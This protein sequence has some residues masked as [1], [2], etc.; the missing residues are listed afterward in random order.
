MAAPIDISVVVPFYNEQQVAREFHRRLSAVME[1]LDGAITWEAVY[2]DDGS[3][4]GTLEVLKE[5]QRTDDRV[6]VVELS[7][8]WGHQPAVMA[9]LCTSR[10]RA[11]VLMDGDL[12][13]PPEVIPDLLAAWREGG[14]VI[15][16]RRRSRAERGVRRW[17]FGAFYAVLGFLTDYPI[18][19]N[20]GI[21]GLLD[22]RV[23]DAIARMTET[24]RYLPGLRSYA[25]FAQRVVSYDRAERAGGEPK[26]TFGRLLKYGLDAIF[27]FSY[28]PLRLATLLGVLVAALAVVYGVALVVFRLLDTGMFGIPVVDGYTSTIVSVLILGALQ[29]ITIGILGEYLGRVYDEVKRRPLFLIS[30]I[31]ASDPTLRDAVMARAQA[32]TRGASQGS[33]S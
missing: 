16:G 25:G 17:M 18:P 4:D 14:Q 29:L 20:A 7:R 27:S 1:K 2:V 32:G 21:F 10:G 9:G 11:V 23:V 24:N 31:H 6:I 30:E 28:K 8:N 33:S 26:Q 13:D 5:A 19:L 22:R 15:I 3:V 12:Q